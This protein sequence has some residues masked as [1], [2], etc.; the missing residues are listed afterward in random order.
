MY[1]VRNAHT[2]QLLYAGSKKLDPSRRYAFTWT[3]NADGD[4]AAMWFIE[5]LDA[6][7]EHRIKPYEKEAKGQQVRLKNV[8]LGE[9][10]YCGSKMLDDGQRVVLTW[11]GK[12]NTDPAMVWSL[13]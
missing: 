13:F 1:H 6:T 10:L 4:K 7:L 2:K 9:Y 3:G 12:A 5:P 8:G 11:I